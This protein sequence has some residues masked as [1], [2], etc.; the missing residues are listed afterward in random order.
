MFNNSVTMKYIKHYIN[1][2]ISY[3]LLNELVK[4]LNV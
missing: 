4:I 1:K 3:I 2:S